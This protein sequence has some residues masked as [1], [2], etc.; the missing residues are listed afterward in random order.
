[1]RAIAC[2]L[3]VALLSACSIGE[4]HDPVQG[5]GPTYMFQGAG[6]SDPAA[7]RAH[8]QRLGELLACSSCHG[9]SYQGGAYTE[10]ADGG[11]VFASNLTL[12]VPRL[13]DEQLTKLLR[14]GVH[15]RRPNLWYMPSKSLQR[16][17]RH[18]MAALVAFLRAL[19]PAGEDW[20]EPQNGETTTALLQLGILQDGP[21]L[22][23]AYR[24]RMP[25][26]L[27]DQVGYGRYI[28][29]VTC[30]ECHGPDLSGEM[31]SAPP[32]GLVADRFD[33]AGLEALTGAGGASTHGEGMMG[34]VAARNLS[35]LTDTERSALVD[36]LLVLRAAQ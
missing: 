35:V 29:S 16:L 21:E 33:R 27:G 36:Y 6:V 24:D 1:M 32:I 34:L 13:S 3:G 19:E 23:E 7:K 25:P 11:Y 31:G 8:G 22:V 4:R 18:D 17:S 10:D 15:P 14:E 20:P 12:A 9:E 30:A 26:D 2:L 28:A 5:P